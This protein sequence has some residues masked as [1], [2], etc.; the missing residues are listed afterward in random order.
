[1]TDK[2]SL[3]RDTAA[4][5]VAIVRLLR[6]NQPDMAMFILSSYADNPDAM[7][8]L[9]AS[10]AAVANALLT[11]IDKLAVE[12]KDNGLSIPTADNCLARAAAAVVSFD[13]AALG[14]PQP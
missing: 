3:T 10:V 7:Q 1:M 14:K 12:A 13:P 8:G 4:D 9:V 5:A 11:V 6:T 2:I